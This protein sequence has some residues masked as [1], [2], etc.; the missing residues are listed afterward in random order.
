[1][2]DK[3]K[4]KTQEKNTYKKYKVKN[5]NMKKMLQHSRL[6]SPNCEFAQ[7]G[8]CFTRNSLNR[9]SHTWEPLNWEF[10]YLGINMSTA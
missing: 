7:Q 10:T 9:E 4:Q 2:K 3:E 1:M 8:L 6:E 5:E